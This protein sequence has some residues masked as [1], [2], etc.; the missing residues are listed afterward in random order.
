MAYLAKD[1][2]AIL[3]DNLGFFPS[4]LLVT[5]KMKLPPLQERFVMLA[6][7]QLAIRVLPKHINIY[8]KRQFASHLS[9]G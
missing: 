9:Q 4:L 6:I 8:K 5:D 1:D 2:H 7:F 3:D